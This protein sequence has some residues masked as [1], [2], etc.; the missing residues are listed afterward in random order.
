MKKL[1]L[2]LLIAFSLPVFGQGLYVDGGKISTIE[3]FT[4]SGDTSYTFKVPVQVYFS[5]QFI[6]TSAD[7]LDARVIP[8]ISND[9]VN[10]KQY[11]ALDSLSLS[12]ASGD[13]FIRSTTATIERYI[14]FTVKH[15]T[16]TA[17]TLT[18]YINFMHKK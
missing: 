9:G 3:T 8:M 15:G 7:S 10:F 17:G 4:L 6:W 18:E 1:I 16:N 12:T 5:A 11:P 14:R 13:G 2:I